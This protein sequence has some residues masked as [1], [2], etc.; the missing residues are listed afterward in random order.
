M[1]VAVGIADRRTTAGWLRL[2]AVLA[3]LG[4]FAAAGGAED[5][6]GTEGAVAAGA[7]RSV[8][9]PGS[10][11][12]DAAAAESAG[13]AVGASGAAGYGV[14]RSEGRCMVPG[15]T[16]GSTGAGCATTGGGNAGGCAVLTT[17]WVS[18]I[19]G[20]GAGAGA[21]ATSA[22]AC[23]PCSKLWAKAT[24]DV[25]AVLLTGTALGDTCGVGPAVG[26][27]GA[28]VP[29]DEVTGE[30]EGFA[31]GV[32]LGGWAEVDVGCRTSGLTAVIVLGPHSS[33]CLRMC[34]A[35]VAGASE[36]LVS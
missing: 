20:A 21:G 9:Y 29:G 36:L 27:A 34:C 16:G 6:A 25:A 30:G 1:S 33:P 8:P 24:G 11:P 28:V 7:R 19:V 14:A 32:G 35:G 26:M 31:C 18:G 12:G 3:V 4:E 5:P 17:G 23:R 15:A 10:G 13:G 22:P 2:W